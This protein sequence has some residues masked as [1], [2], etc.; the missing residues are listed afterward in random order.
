MP[1]RGGFNDRRRFERAYQT[2]RGCLTPDRMRRRRRVGHQRMR[3]AIITADMS[4]TGLCGGASG[5]PGSA[6]GVVDPPGWPA[7]LLLLSLLS[8]APLSDMA[9][10][11]LPLSSSLTRKTLSL[12]SERRMSVLLAMTSASFRLKLIPNCRLIMLRPGSLPKKNRSPSRS[13]VNCFFHSASCRG[14]VLLVR[15]TGFRS[16]THRRTFVGMVVA[17]AGEPH[18]ANIGIDQWV[19]PSRLRPGYKRL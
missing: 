7:S 8:E 10:S 6:V 14:N 19:P 15:L 4:D 9:L 17:P 16:Q 1:R 2:S 11:A 13:A 18:H 12:R 5:L 3:S